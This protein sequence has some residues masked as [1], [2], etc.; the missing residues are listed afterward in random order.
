MEEDINLWT[1]NV[2]NIEEQII[3]AD[4][5]SGQAD[6]STFDVDNTDDSSNVDSLNIRTSNVQSSEIDTVA[7]HPNSIPTPYSPG[8]GGGGSGISNNNDN[9]N[10]NDNEQ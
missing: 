4:N 9:N 6:I 7:P 10:N 3:D 1:S 2:R 8:F 5:V